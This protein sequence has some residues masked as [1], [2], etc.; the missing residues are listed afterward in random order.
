M[1]LEHN[2]RSTWT[3]SLSIQMEFI[4]KR[5]SG[6]RSIGIGWEDII[7]PGIKDR[8]RCVDSRNVG[9]S[10]WD[11]Q[12]G[13]IECVVSLYD[14]RRWKWDDVYLLQGLPKIYTQYNSVHLP[15]L[16][17]HRIPTVAPSGCTWRPGSRNCGDA[18]GDRDQV[19]SEMRFEAVMERVWRCTWRQRSIEIGG[20]LGGGW[21]GGD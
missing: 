9:Q 4:S 6:S 15:L 12:L 2:R 3:C 7:L 18:L 14:M 20:V 16:L 10:E 21:R 5:S 8:H 19:N 13:K 17:Y 1:V 11:Q